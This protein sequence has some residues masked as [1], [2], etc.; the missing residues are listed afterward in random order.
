M[1]GGGE[2]GEMRAGLVCGEN[3]GLGVTDGTGVVSPI[4]PFF[5]HEYF[6]FLFPRQLLRIQGARKVLAE[7]ES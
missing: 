3:E 6:P 4:F 1:V 2:R 7:M 5:F